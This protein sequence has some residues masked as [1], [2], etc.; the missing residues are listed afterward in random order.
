MACVT[1]LMSVPGASRTVL[2]VVIP[3]S[4]QALQELVGEAG[5]AV[6]IDTA[7]ALAETAY[8]RACELRPGVSTPVVGIACTAAL[9]TDR[10]R[11]GRDR[12]CIAWVSADHQGAHEVLLT[13]T[14]GSDAKSGRV[15]QDR[16]V[17][18]ALLETVVTAT[19]AMPVG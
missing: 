11:R 15:A 5:N 16:A 18:D 4:D 9:V 14:R 8:A 1:D 19:T 6:S 3:Y 2:E 10:E 17:A 12:A 7:Q 13:K